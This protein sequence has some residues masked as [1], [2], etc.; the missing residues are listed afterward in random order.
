MTTGERPILEG[1]FRSFY[2]ILCVQVDTMAV[3][4]F[5]STI[6]SR[7]RLMP[8]PTPSPTG[9]GLQSSVPTL[10]RDRVD[11]SLKKNIEVYLHTPT[12]LKKNIDPYLHTFSILKKNIYPYLHTSFI[13]LKE[14]PYFYMF[15]YIYLYSSILILDAS[16]RQR[17]KELGLSSSLR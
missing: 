4:F 5:I 15:P 11:A 9:V 2:T 3:S 17:A 14:S 7:R 8:S 1:L 13:M 6:P 12:F 16:E 10:A